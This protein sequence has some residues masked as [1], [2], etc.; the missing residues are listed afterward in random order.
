MEDGIGSW[1]R[2]IIRCVGVPT[3][4]PIAYLY[5]LDFR[6][7]DV[8]FFKFFLDEW[9]VYL[10]VLFSS[11]KLDGMSHMTHVSHVM[12]NQGLCHDS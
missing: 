1:I 2:K 12:M 9:V 11:T 3:Y 10:Y 4:V 8:N 7:M 6:K 5:R